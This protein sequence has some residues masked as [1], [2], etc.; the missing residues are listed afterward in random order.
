VSGA[1]GGDVRVSV[2]IP[3]WHDAKNLAVLLPQ[4]ARIDG[5][6]DVIVCDA[7]ND[8]EAQNLTQQFG[9]MFVRCSAPN[10]GAQMN[11]GILFASGNVLLFH[12]ADV[13]LRAEHLQALQRAMRNPDTIGGAFHRLYGFVSLDPGRQSIFVRRDALF[14]LGG[15]AK[16]P[17]IEDVEFL[18]R[19]RASGKTVLLD[20]PVQKL[21]QRSVRPGAW[22][23]NMQ[24]ALF[25][26]L[27]KCGVGAESLR[28]WYYRNDVSL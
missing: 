6:V 25:V 23:R 8:L 17:L 14:Q 28:R 16:V 10:R 5:I 3:A 12:P 21:P 22:R 11:A 4:I 1:P 26:L 15:F 27:Y 7:S 2:I 9:T 13:D 20:P 19:L 24:T 18:R